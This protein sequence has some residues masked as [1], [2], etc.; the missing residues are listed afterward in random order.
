[1]DA[2]PGRQIDLASAVVDVE[3]SRG[4]TGVGVALSDP[5]R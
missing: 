2:P 4:H 3:P 5:E 1:M